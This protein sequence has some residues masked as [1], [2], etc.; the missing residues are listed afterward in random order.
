[1]EL[2]EKNSKT[3]GKSSLIEESYINWGD[4]LVTFLVYGAIILFVIV[5]VRWVLKKRRN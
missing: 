1:M 4:L 3:K 2:L 5:L